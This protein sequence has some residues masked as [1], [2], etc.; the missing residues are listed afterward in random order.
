MGK[1]RD[2]EKAFGLGKG[3]LRAYF[4]TSMDALSNPKTAVSSLVL[5]IL[6]EMVIRSFD[7]A[8]TEAT[9]VLILACALALS[10]LYSRFYYER[11]LEEKSSRERVP[12]VGEMILLR[13]R[14]TN[15]EV[16]RIAYW[17]LFLSYPAF[18]IMDIALIIGVVLRI[19][20]I[21]KAFGWIF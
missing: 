11:R 20:S 3:V 16:G 18:V 17:L 9:Y 10:F 7:D 19:V 8:F 14:K 21:I 13:K 2:S 15:E 1:E 4:K 12:Y 6:M 5:L